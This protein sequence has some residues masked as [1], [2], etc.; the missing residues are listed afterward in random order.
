M[1]RLVVALLLVIAISVAAA[2]APVAATRAAVQSSASSKLN[3]PGRPP[4]DYSTT[5]KIASLGQYVTWRALVGTA[6]ANKRMD[7]EI[8]VKRGG[9]WGPWSALTTRAVDAHGVLQF[10]WRYNTS[11]AWISIR[12]ARRDSP[13]RTNAIQARW[14]RPPTP[15]PV[16]I[17]GSRPFAAP[18]TTRTVN[19]P[20]TI[21]A[22][23][24]SD[25]SA[26]LLSFINGVPDGSVIVFKA[27]GVYRLDRGIRVSDRHNLV[28][29][30]NG[31]TLRTGGTLY[32]TSMWSIPFVIYGSSSD[33]SD[34][35]IRNF[36]IEGPNTRTGTNVYD[37]AVE[38]PH[39]VGVYG[40]SRIEIAHNT[41]R[42]TGGDGVYAANG[43]TQE[44]VNGLWVH[45][46]T[47]D[48]IGRNAFTM[49][50]VR[51]ALLE[52]N[53]ID[54]VG[55]SVL[56]IEPDEAFQGAINT[57]LRDNNV[58]IWGMSPLYTMHF[59]ACANDNSGPGAVIR[60]LT[61]TGNHVSQGAPNSANT[62]NA[63]GLKT[64]IGKTRTSNVTFANNTTTKAGAGP[65]L[66]FE[67]VDGLTVTGN[68]QPLT[69]G[70][71]T[72]VSDSTNVEMSQ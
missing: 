52:R 4:F 23:G 56:D 11:P 30:G 42:K 20:T 26:A 13:Y 47:F 61:I 57:T 15:A 17:S 60:G 49:N 46:N 50:A 5:T 67:H 53:T 27:G 2:F 16:P 38:S 7:V 32:L 69:S 48:Y 35:V 58:G 18:V 68:A 51:N 1:S 45:D 70:S 36:T 64:W 8:A 41:I 65:V 44:W 39:G 9:V 28:F 71:L 40:G 55:A 31:A 33:V 10:S 29:E 22:T 19:V 12:F 63:G 43:S 3:L 59:V 72:Y 62:P 14:I 21:D 25:A 24:A 66:V 54:H 6:N 37:P 34:I